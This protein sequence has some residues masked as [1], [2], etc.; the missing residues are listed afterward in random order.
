MRMSRV[1]VLLLL[2]AL[3]SGC[4]G[5]AGPADAG[6]PPA[7]CPAQF[8][9]QDAPWVPED[10]S[11]Q[12]EGRLVPDA[13]PVTAVV[14]RYQA[15][16]F[17]G[18]AGEDDTAALE[19]QVELAGGLEHLRHD[20]LLPEELDGQDR[21]CTLV[22]APTTPYLMRLDYADGS[23]WLAAVHDANSCQSS[24]NGDFTAHAYLGTRLKE[25]FDRRAWSPDPAPT[26]CFASGRGRAGQ[27]RTLVPD[28]WR[29]AGV[30]TSRV[31]AGPPPERPLAA[32]AAA[33]V[34]DLL[35]DVDTEPGSGGCSGS[36]EVVHHVLFRYE[37]GP[38]VT[39]SFTPGCDPPLR[40]GSLDGRLSR[41]Q[42]RDLEAL[43][44]E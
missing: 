42:A 16:G 34:A 26:G 39:V 18:P 4:A 3:L 25:A 44:R 22:G 17:D 15:R 7:D 23:L 27:E 8:P 12:T 40:N 38:P 36:G 43:V 19:E 1:A 32:D 30:C 9:A 13:D 33:A 37:Q 6:R 28:G 24:G 21:F 10:P 5:S 20:L 29:T 41:E 11:T 35:A 14:C 31:D 2:A